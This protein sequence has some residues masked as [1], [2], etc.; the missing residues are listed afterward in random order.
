M[1][2]IPLRETAGPR[3]LK[4]K[5]LKTPKIPKRES[6]GTHIFGG[7]EITTSQSSMR[8]KV[9]RWRQEF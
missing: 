9:E 1:T 5:T 3:V 7:S 2:P 4:T 8:L 6:K